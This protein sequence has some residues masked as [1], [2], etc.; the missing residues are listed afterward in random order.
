[1]TVYFYNSVIRQLMSVLS[2][3][4]NLEAQKEAALKQAKNASD[5]ANRQMEKAEVLNITVSAIMCNQTL[6]CCRNYPVKLIKN[7][8]IK[9]TKK[10]T[11]SH[12][13][14]THL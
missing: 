12:L 9:N 14:I 8:L 4:A 3:Q 6:C 7:K 1:M 11:I 10:V 13:L 2:E 5:E